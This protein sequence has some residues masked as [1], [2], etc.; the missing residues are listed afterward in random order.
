MSLRI[1]LMSLR[2][3][4]VFLAMGLALP[5]C[6]EPPP[7]AYVHGTADGPAGESVSVGANSAGESCTEQ[8]A[9]GGG[10]AVYCGTWAQPSARVTEGGAVSPDGLMSLATSS[11]WRSSLEV[12]YDCGAPQ[13]TRVL[14]R[15]PAVS[16]PCTRKIGGWP[17][18][19]I[20]ASIDGRA[21]LGDGVQPAVP[22]LERTIGVLSGAIKPEAAAA[23]GSTAGLAASRLAAQAFS[24]GDIGQYETLMR[25]GERANLGQNYA[26]AEQAYRAAAA[27]Q[28][29]V[30]GRG[31]PATATAITSEALQVSD[32]GRFSEAAGLFA[33]AA[34]LAYSPDQKDRTAAPRLAHYRALDLLN[35][36]KPDE[37]MPLL[38]QAEAGYSAIL[39]SQ[40]LHGSDTGATSAPRGVTLLQDRL[41]NAELGIDAIAVN[42]LYGAIEARRARAVAFRM[43]GKLPES[44]A[45]NRAAEQLAGMRGLAHPEVAA[46]IYRV[47]ANIATTAGRPGEAIDDLAESSTDFARGLPGT[48]PFAVTSLLWARVLMDEKRPGDALAHCRTARDVLSQAQAGTTA[49]LMQPCILAYVDQAKKDPEHAQAILADMFEAAQQVQGSVT[50]AQIAQATARLTENARDPKVA[51]LIRAKADTNTLLA[52]LYEQRDEA[53]NDKTARKLTPAEAEALDKKIHDAQAAQADTDAA[54]QAASPNYGQLVQTVVKAGDVLSLLHPGEAF[55]ATILTPDSGTTF[56]LRDGQIAAAPIDGGE[57]RIAALVDRVRAAMEVDDT[58]TPKPFDAAAAQELYQA[59]FGGVADRMQGATALSV[60]PAGPLL[61]IPYGL[62]LTGPADPKNLA[63]APFLIRQ[64]TVAHVPA[65]ANFVTLRKLAASK[66]AEPWFGFG[67][68]KPVTRAQAEKSFPSAACKESAQLLAGLPLLPGARAELEVARKVEGAGANDELLGP[69]FTEPAVVKAPLKGF[70][71]LHFATHALLPTDIACQ[72][73]PA[74]VGS[75]PPGATDA[76]KA[77]LTASQVAG[78]DLDADTVI[79]SACNTGGPNGAAGESLSGLARS[80]F[81]AGA[82]SLLVA[83]WAVNDRYAAY[84]VALTLSKAR[85]APGPSFAAALAAAQRQILDEAKGDLAGQAHPFYWAPLALIG[86]GSGGASAKLAGL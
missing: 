56:L 43:E 59:V 44:A 25:A 51:E 54:L 65:P 30:L 86:E 7:E 34:P 27:L 42:A 85:G 67:E 33:R 70:R 40:I 75:D 29:K 21:W 15:F 8:A 23:A 6:A 55:A 74:I 1:R 49:E 60:V 82:R 9:P 16:I 36:N 31:N 2:I 20:A 19:A 3:R 48:K 37:A 61:S 12:R 68:F 52:S 26:E 11:P 32:Q 72:T 13:P 63:D 66:G 50:S 76:S 5:G 18:V 41:Q 47:S 24:S 4:P 46:R 83:H 69:A 77:L 73:E 58:G 80:F 22:A 17:Q 35:Q 45:A 78:M 57:K 39:P 28:E 81:Y 14:D 38:D 64:A 62:L 53:A 71:I 10:A 84:L 79:L